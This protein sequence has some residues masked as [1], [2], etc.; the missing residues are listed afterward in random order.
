M[1]KQ[2]RSDKNVILKKVLIPKTLTVFN[3]IFYKKELII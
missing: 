3:N 2:I 1:S